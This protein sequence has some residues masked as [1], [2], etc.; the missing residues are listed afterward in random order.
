MTWIPDSGDMVDTK[1][2][3]NMIYCS[4]EFAHPLGWLVKAC[5]G[6]QSSVPRLLGSQTSKAMVIIPAWSFFVLS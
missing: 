2:P 6:R 1:V 4:V 5:A 3:K